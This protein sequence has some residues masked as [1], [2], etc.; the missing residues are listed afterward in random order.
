MSAKYIVHIIFIDLDGWSLERNQELKDAVL[1][2]RRFATRV[3]AVINVEVSTENLWDF[4]LSPWLI[5]DN[6][7]KSF[8]K[9]SDVSKII[10]KVSVHFAGNC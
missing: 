6:E 1:N 9:V 7:E 10:T 2:V 3:S 4:S 8:I 5:T